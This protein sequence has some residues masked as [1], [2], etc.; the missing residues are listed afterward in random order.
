MLTKTLSPPPTRI[1]VVDDEAPVRSLLDRVL[2]QSGFH[3]SSAV[4]GCEGL[5]CVARENPDLV[6]LDLNLPDLSGEDVCQKIRQTPRIQ[7]VPVMILTGRTT[8]GLSAQCLNGGA[9]DYLSKPFDIQELVAR[10]RALLRRP[11]LYASSEAVI[12]RQRIII[13]GA[14]HRILWDGRRVEDLAPKEYELLRHLIL[15]SPRVVGKNALALK[16]WGIPLD[17]IHQRTLDVHI[18]R[19][20]K[21]IGAEGARCLKTIPCI[22]YQWLDKP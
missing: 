21:K 9:D 14:E 8:R 22:G 6:I 7:E 2:R 11:S 3:V 10:V 4:N 20:R 19:I 18:R 12:K 15:L 1:L 17:Q 13:N 5:E 16:V